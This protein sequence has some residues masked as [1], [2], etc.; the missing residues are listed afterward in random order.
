[1]VTISFRIYDR[2]I[3]HELVCRIWRRG[4]SRKAAPLSALAGAVE[5][6][7]RSA[8]HDGEWRKTML[9]QNMTLP[10]VL[11]ARTGGC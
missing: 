7:L 11:R 9:W 10:R 6:N 1:M 4:H 2:D 3:I 8:T 5:L